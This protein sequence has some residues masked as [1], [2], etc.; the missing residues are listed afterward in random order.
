MSI[1]GVDLLEINIATAPAKFGSVGLG[2]E[3]LFECS[4]VT[5][6]AVILGAEVVLCKGEARV[7]RH[8]VFR[9]PQ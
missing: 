4:P 2:L 1:R 8:G 6:D 9:E 7:T 5:K 3:M